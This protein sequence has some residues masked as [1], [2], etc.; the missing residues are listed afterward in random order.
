MRLIEKG[1]KI[2]SGVFIAAGLPHKQAL[3]RYR[4]R[5]QQF[6]AAFQHPLLLFS[7]DVGPGGHNIW[8]YLAAPIYQEPLFIWLTGINQY[9]CALYL[10]PRR[11]KEILFLPP[12]D[13][14]FE[15]WQ[16]KRLGGGDPLGQ[17]TARK[18]TGIQTIKNIKHLEDFLSRQFKTKESNKNNPPQT[19]GLLWYENKEPS[20][21]KKPKEKKTSAGRESS[22]PPQ[23]PK[24]TII[25]D[26]NWTQG[27]KAKKA[28]KKFNKNVQFKNIA[29]KQFSLRLPLDAVDVRNAQKAGKLTAEAFKET[30][31]QI[32]SC[33]FEYEIAGLLEGQMLKRT[34]Y[35]KSFPTIAASGKNATILHYEKYDDKLAPSELFLLDFGLRWGT[36]HAD[37]SRTLPLCGHFN[38]L[39]KLLY[40]VC[41]NTQKR[42]EKQARAGMTIK[43][44][45]DMCWDTLEKGLKVH[46]LDRGG[47]M[48][49]DYDKAPH[50]V[51][52]LM[53]EME[54]DGDPFG[55]YKNEPMEAG[56][57][58]SNEP[59]LYGRFSITIG[60]ERYDEHL[61]IR[62]EDNLL[63]TKKGCVNLSKH[64]PKEIAD[65]EGLMNN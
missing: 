58:I 37:I 52:H 59:G 16:G 9:P 4:R 23:K 62:L 28:I 53:G 26:S 5:R 35:G 32:K 54:H 36:M 64:V 13:P 3:D 41:L 29:K 34:P 17:E 27:E 14:K 6:V 39:Q 51:S 21:L 60:G 57:M 50:G 55:A 45:N 10:E 1:K 49:R 12:N 65:I 61:G 2:Y 25:K 11:K 8:P 56:W 38:P 40:E 24:K 20:A 42:V 46:F 30:L 44:L 22:A 43:T 18:V 33:R 48:K 15:F 47:R 31:P 7:V 19:L 63:I